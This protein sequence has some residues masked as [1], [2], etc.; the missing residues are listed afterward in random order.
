MDG[1]ALTY[2]VVSEPAHG[3]LLGVLPNL[4]YAPELGYFG[5]D[6]FSFTAN[7]GQ[8]T[9]APATITIN[10][11]CRP[12]ANAGADQTGNIG[13]VLTFSAAASIDPDGTIANNYIWNWGDNTA[14]SFSTVTATHSY[15]N[16]GTYTVTLT[17]FDNDGATATDTLI[18]SVNAPPTAFS[19]AVTTGE[20]TAVVVT[21]AATDT[22]GDTLTYAVVTG[23]A[24]GTLSGTAP[25]LT[26]TPAANYNGPD[27]FTFVANDGTVDSNTAT[28]SITVTT[29]ND[30]PVAAGQSRTAAEDTALTV[31]LSATDI[32]GDALT[33]AVATGPAHGTLSGTAPNLT[34][35]PAAN[36]N[37]PDSFTFVANDGTVDSNV[38]TVSITVTA[39]NDLPAANAGADQTGLAGQVLS[40]S[41][42]A[43]SDVEGPIA[44]Y[45]WNWG[46]GT[47]NGAGVSPTHA[48][49]VAGTYTVTLTVTDSNSATATDTLVVT[50]NKVNLALN[51]SASASTTYDSATAAAKAVD[52]LTATYWR[53]GK[54][55]GT[56]WLR[57][58]LGTAKSVSNV[59][60]FWPATYYA[61]SFKIE[62]STDGTNWT[63]RYETTTGTG[64]VTNATF[65]AVSARYVR[66]SC[67]KANSTSYRVTELEVYQ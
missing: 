40:F 8:A 13:Q 52:G 48:W 24:H 3:E 46:D 18:V 36:Y 42:A 49:T 15:S 5:P 62:T 39:V 61:K 66:V 29:S 38:A 35:T 20:D 17:V 14:G 63:K 55:S 32:D 12:I 37:G 47:A 30:P 19:Q 65:T 28:V 1:D 51:K 33:Y 7:D 60:V 58:D 31:T 57:V 25:N 6:S 67:T 2:T 59:K 16:P 50:V 27:S 64:G 9:S 41:G 23:P 56:Q 54:I 53:S 45:S 4:T 10:V 21:L 26:Y 34:Y 43:S 11:N 44:S 22:D